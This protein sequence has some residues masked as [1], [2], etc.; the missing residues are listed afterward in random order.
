MLEG[1]NGSA[2][3]EGLNVN[4]LGDGCVAAFALTSALAQSE[5]PLIAATGEFMG[6]LGLGGTVLD[7]V[8][9]A[10]LQILPFVPRAAGDL[11]L[12]SV[13]RGAIDLALDK[14]VIQSY[15]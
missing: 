14:R 3:G 10:V 1:S 9:A 13:I 15:P 7:G 5:G 6:A 11:V 4:L 12:Y 8:A 2:Q